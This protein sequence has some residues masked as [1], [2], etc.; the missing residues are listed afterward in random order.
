MLHFVTLF[1]ESMIG[2]GCGDAGGADTRFQNN[3]YLKPKAPILPDGM[4]G[5]I[6]PNGKPIRYPNA[7]HV[8]LDAATGRFCSTPG[9]SMYTWGYEVWNDT[10]SPIVN[11]LRNPTMQDYS[12]GDVYI[13]FAD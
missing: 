11:F 9:I 5:R 8:P 10:N 7:V 12:C 3:N 13:N 1:R 2:T 6:G 4:P